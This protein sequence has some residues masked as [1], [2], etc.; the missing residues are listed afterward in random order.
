MVHWSSCSQSTCNLPI[1]HT[2]RVK[3]ARLVVP[4][5][6]SRYWSCDCTTWQQ[7]LSW[8]EPI[9]WRRNSENLNLTGLSHDNPTLKNT[10]NKMLNFPGESGKCSTSLHPVVGR[11]TT[12]QSTPWENKF[13]R[14]K[15]RKETLPSDW[16]IFHPQQEKLS[17]H[18]GRRHWG[19]TTLSCTYIT[20]N[21]YMNVHVDTATLLVTRCVQHRHMICRFQM[22]IVY[23]W[24]L[25]LDTSNTRF[26]TSDKIFTFWYYR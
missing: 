22:V 16:N 5:N 14:E 10:R 26:L 25:L 9:H 3:N 7:C 20:K 18:H 11:R 24:T 19:N 4:A 15:D 23:V 17:L 1:H 2:L 6:Q 21:R 13:L 12:E 8:D